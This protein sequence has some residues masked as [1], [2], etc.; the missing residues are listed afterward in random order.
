MLEVQAFP[1]FKK[2][3]HMCAAAFFTIQV[4]VRGGVEAP[5]RISRI[6]H[7]IYWGVGPK[8]WVLLSRDLT[9]FPNKL[10]FPPR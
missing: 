9:T 5:R 10:A 6:Y 4:L 7:G 1:K 8:S 2:E 3:I